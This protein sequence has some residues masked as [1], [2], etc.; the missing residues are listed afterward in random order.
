MPADARS[1]ILAAIRSA[2]GG[3]TDPARAMADYAQI[4]R[5]YIQTSS[6][7]CDK[8]QA[9]LTERLLDYNAH[10][11][12]C[13]ADQVP[14]AIRDALQHHNARRILIPEDFPAH[15]VPEGFEVTGSQAHSSSGRAVLN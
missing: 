1:L 14:S 9:L 11:V 15:F 4:P 5:T 8:R 13:T 3:A 2:N 12:P 7:S 6:L 10:V